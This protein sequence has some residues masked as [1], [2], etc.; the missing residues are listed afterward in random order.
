MTKRKRR[1][2]CKGFV[3]ESMD[4]YDFDCEYENAG[5]IT[6]EHCVMCG[7]LFSPQTG[8]LFRGNL[9]LYEIV[10]DERDSDD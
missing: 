4:G 10:R 7:G 2:E 1:Y 8:K 5:E 3:V 9:A 6:C